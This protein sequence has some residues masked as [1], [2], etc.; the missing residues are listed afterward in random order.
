MKYLLMIRQRPSLQLCKFAP[1]KFG[2]LANFFDKQSEVA[3]PQREA[4]KT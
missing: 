3:R 1:Y 2:F 4:R